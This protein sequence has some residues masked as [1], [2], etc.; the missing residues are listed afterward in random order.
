MSASLLLDQ[1]GHVALQLDVC[2]SWRF[3]T[4]T[5]K[6]HP[7]PP[8]IFPEFWPKICSELLKVA[9]FDPESA[10]AGS[11]ILGDDSKL[12]EREALHRTPV[13]EAPPGESPL[14]RLKVSAKVP[15]LS[16]Q[17]KKRMKKIRHVANRLKMVAQKMQ[18]LKEKFKKRLAMKKPAATAPT[19]KRILK[20]TSK[21]KAAPAAKAGAEATPKAKAAPAAKAVPEATPKAKAAAKPPVLRATSKAAPKAAAASDEGH[22]GQGRGA[23]RSI[24]LDFAPAPLGP[25]EPTSEELEALQAEYPTIKKDLGDG[26]P[27]VKLRHWMPMHHVHTCIHC[28]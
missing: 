8:S 28:M 10:T 23:R 20:A 9:P 16:D 15:L 17:R 25:P 18:K 27:K 1:C 7:H 19:T 14:E 13:P 3:P 11:S 12:H 21:A 4:R 2:T 6:R 24:L 22:A 5:Q 26:H